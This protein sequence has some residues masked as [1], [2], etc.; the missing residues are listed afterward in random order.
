MNVLS[1]LLQALPQD[2]VAARYL[3][4]V[5]EYLEFCTMLDAAS[6]LD[7]NKTRAQ[8]KALA[9]RGLHTALQKFGDRSVG[10]SGI[11]HPC[12]YLYRSIDLPRVSLTKVWQE[13]LKG[14]PAA[15]PQEL[16]EI[17]LSQITVCQGWSPAAGL[18][19]T[20]MA[21]GSVEYW[22][23]TAV[24]NP[25]KKPIEEIASRLKQIDV[26]LE[27][28]RVS[29]LGPTQDAVAQAGLEAKVGL[30]ACDISLKDIHELMLKIRP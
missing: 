4:G 10:W 1:S 20:A 13:H 28:L 21:L 11:L 19:L 8:A 29:Y 18:D 14:S 17:P 24:E 15:G 3:A 22:L 30:A 26:Q 25:L 12:M 27:E 2:K 5:E 16:F 23:T 6:P 9:Q 7:V